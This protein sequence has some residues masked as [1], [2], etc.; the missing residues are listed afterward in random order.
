PGPRVAESLEILAEILHPAEFDF[1]H[2]GTG[3]APL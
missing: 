1:G 2:K 3:W